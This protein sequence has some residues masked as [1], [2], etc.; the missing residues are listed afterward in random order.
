MVLPAIRIGFMES[1][2]HKL[3]PGLAIL[4]VC[5]VCLFLCI[6]A[7]FH[8]GPCRP[9]PGIP[10]NKLSWMGF[11]GD[12]IEVFKAGNTMDWLLEQ[13]RKHGPICQLF[14]RPLKQPFV[15]ISDYTVAQAIMLK[16]K[17]WDRSDYSIELLSGQAPMHHINLK[18]GPE[19][20]AH[21]KLIQDLMGQ[22]FLNNVA[23]PNI[24]SS[25]LNLV[26]LW[27][28]KERTA[29]GHAFSA[30]DDVIHSTLDAAWAFTFGDAFPVKAIHQGT[31][32]CAPVTFTEHKVTFGSPSQLPAVEATLGAS[33]IVGELAASPCPTTSWYIM[34]ATSKRV[35]RHLAIRREYVQ[36]QIMAAVERLH[37]TDPVLAEGKVKFTSATDF[38]VRRVKDCAESAGEVPDYLSETVFGLIIG[39]HDTTSTTKSWGLKHLADNQIVQDRL[40]A[41]LRASFSLATQERRMPTVQ[42]ITGTCIPYLDAVLEEI[43]RLAC[44]LAI[45]DR[46]ATCDTEVLGHHIP[47]GTIVMMLNRGPSFTEPAFD[48]ALAGGLSVAGTGSS[49]VVHTLHHFMPERWLETND[50]GRSFFNPKAGP[51][52]PFGSGPRSC[53]GRKLGYLDLRIVFVLL[54]WRFK[55]HKCAPELSTYDAVETLTYKPERC[56]VNL[57]SIKE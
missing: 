19:W 51:T 25:T 13:S 20:R 55:L 23:A 4:L 48:E 39:G 37:V 30:T 11:K 18:T 45:L 21:R 29:N 57:E 24:Y 49:W 35:K 14:L 41:S 2:A 28:M 3:G 38:V 8:F 34:R 42:E 40:R 9:L 27:T 50:Q 15:L 54:V 5:L 53:Y 47:K 56:Y 36:E 52:L 10:R 43:L 31:I 6:Q 12:I 7:F 26:E 16:R 46:Q 32:S 33:D 22:S 1:P 17:E 44:S